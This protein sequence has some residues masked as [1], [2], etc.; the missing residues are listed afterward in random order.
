MPSYLVKL[1]QRA[2]KLVKPTRNLPIKK[3]A[4]G[5]LYTA[6]EL[7]NG[8]TGVSFT[9]TDR[10]T[11]FEGYHRLIQNGLLSEKPLLE[12]IEYCS[13]SHAI[14][15]TIGVAALNTYCQAHIDF[16]TALPKDVL[17]ILSP[18]PDMMIGMVGNIHPISRYFDKKGIR[19]R[20]LDK[21]IPVPNT[22]NISQVNEIKDLKM[23][24]N[25]LIS[26]SALVFDNLDDIINILPHI[27]GKKILV[28]PSAQIFPQLAFELGFSSVCSSRIIDSNMTTK[29]IQ[30]GGGYKYFRPFT[31]K[32]TFLNI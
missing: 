20:I 22:N 6:I 14:F 28:G 5:I 12:L 29:I 15:R 13:S 10:T 19:M 4:I 31:E 25:L 2:L 27:P 17:E 1:A 16:S 8:T 11:D 23:V 26:G 18:T 21:F 32:Y 24:D 3:V 9:L 7:Q 30:E